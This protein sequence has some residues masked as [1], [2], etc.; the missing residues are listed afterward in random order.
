MNTTPVNMF[1]PVKYFVLERADETCGC[2]PESIFELCYRTYTHAISV[3]TDWL[4]MQPDFVLAGRV[5]RMGCFT[6]GPR[7]EYRVLEGSRKI[8]VSPRCVRLSWNVE[9][10]ETKPV[11]DRE[12]R[13]IDGK[14]FV[15]E[16]KRDEVVTEW[17]PEAVLT[18]ERGEAAQM[19]PRIYYMTI[20][21]VERELKFA[22][23]EA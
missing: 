8:T 23:E 17:Q 14:T 21:I 12:T 3:A 19:K 22:P 10:R 15:S 16:T 6:P 4:T 7:K 1:E 5:D 20:E 18:S 9:W 2:G 13:E 11:I